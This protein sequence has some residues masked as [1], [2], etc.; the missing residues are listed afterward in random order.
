VA[1]D[2]WS[3]T[4]S[5]GWLGSTEDEREALAD[6]LA[7]R[8]I[9]DPTHLMLAEGTG[10]LHVALGESIR[11]V[12]EEVYADWGDSDTG[13]LSSNIARCLAWDLLTVILADAGFRRSEVPEPSVEEW[14]ARIEAE[15]N[16]AFMQGCTPQHDDEH[17][18]QHL[19]A[20]AIDY[21]RRGKAEASS[22]LIR[23]AMYVLARL[24]EVAEPQ[25]E[26]S[27]AL[28]IPRPHV[29]FG[30]TGVPELVADAVYLDHA[31]SNLEGKFEVGGSNVRATV[32]K[33]LRDTAV[34]R[35]AASA[36]TEQGE[37]R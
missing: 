8:L 2:G 35:R 4:T 21:A 34:A 20:W 27:D 6:R 28:T 3:R 5:T 14:N 16:K 37:N 30:P 10:A 9:E 33:L 22:G 7:R 32:V 1:A 23:S 18:V 17:G 31:A 19:L 24:A 12:I 11:S 15:R 13:V 29:P 25:S 36:D 26:P